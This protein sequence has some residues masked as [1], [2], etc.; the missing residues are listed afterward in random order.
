M[1]VQLR[2]T[3]TCSSMDSLTHT[4]QP[5]GIVS[6]ESAITGGESGGLEGSNG[7]SPA[8]EEKEAS[9]CSPGQAASLIHC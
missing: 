7:A 1:T 2:S 9:H 3:V 5:I 6:P 8:N 4:L